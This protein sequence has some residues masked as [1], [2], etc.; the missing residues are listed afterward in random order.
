MSNENK[1]TKI[2]LDLLLVENGYYESRTKAEI[3]IREG[4]ILVN[5]IKEDKPGTMVK[6]DST[7]RIIGNKCPFVSRGGYKLDKA[8]KVFNINLKDFICIDLGS[9]T[10]GFTDVMLKNNASK[11]Y[12]VDCGTNQLDFKLRINDKVIVMEN[13]NA[14]YVNINDFNNDTIDFISADLSFISLKLVLNVIYGLLKNNGESI[15]LIKPQFEAGRE[16]VEKGGVIKDKKVHISVI[17]EIIEFAKSI[18][19]YING[20]TYSPIKGPNGNIEYLLYISK[21]DDNKDLLF[22]IED[23]VNASHEEL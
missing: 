6:V 5:N 19:F 22:S 13:T 8:I 17:K 4:N 7:I 2:R 11:V 10:G 3:A 18:G 15:V 14:R 12:A 23:V 9:S 21:K 1:K 16:Y 20:I